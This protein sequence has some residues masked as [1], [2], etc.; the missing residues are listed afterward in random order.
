MICYILYFLDILLY[1]LRVPYAIYI[2]IFDDIDNQT[3]YTQA[4]FSTHY[5]SIHLIRAPSKNYN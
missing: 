2:L 5:R 3:K 4:Y 1:I